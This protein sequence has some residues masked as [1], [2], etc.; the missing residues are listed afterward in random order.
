MPEPADFAAKLRYWGVDDDSLLLAYDDA[1]GMW[2]SRFW[3]M[4][5][6]WLGHAQVAV[7]DGGLRRWRELGLPTTAGIPAARDPGSFT[8]RPDPTA[9]V[10]ELAGLPAGTR[11]VLWFALEMG[12]GRTP[13]EAAAE[14]LLREGLVRAS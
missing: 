6:R 4:T 14:R 3:W 9:V 5:A 10:E 12:T 13:A 8:A 11:F 2:A 7:L 1:T